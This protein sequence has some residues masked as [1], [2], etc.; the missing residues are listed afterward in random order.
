MRLESP[1]GRNDA[2]AT[3]GMTQSRDAANMS[4][5]RR[6]AHPNC[7]VCSPANRSGLQ[8][9]F[10]V[11]E[12][13][14]VETTFDCDE[15]FEGYSGLLHGGAI[16]SLLDG[17]MANCLFAQ[18]RTGLTGELKVRFRKPVAV[19]RPSRVR[20]WIDYASAPYFIL[21]AE[22]CQDGR[23]KAKAVGKFIEQAAS[24]LECRQASNAVSELH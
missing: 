4:T 23:L 5:I 22:L 7:V 14:S 9:R 13:G 3:P 2:T 12:D 8:L 10:E 21:K 15:R 20:A 1:G 17:A 24:Q 19:D 18:G 11:L 16:S 6:A